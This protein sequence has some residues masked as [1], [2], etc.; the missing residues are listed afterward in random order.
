MLAYA[1]MLKEEVLVPLGAAAAA[2]LPPG[3]GDTLLSFKGASIVEGGLPNPCHPT[4]RIQVLTVYMHTLLKY[5]AFTMAHDRVLRRGRMDDRDG[6]FAQENVFAIHPV[7]T[8]V[9]P[10]EAYLWLGMLQHQVYQHCKTRG[11]L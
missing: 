8:G 7:H 1:L 4:K 5:P 2:D 3:Y 10:K 9:E 11:Y 6:I